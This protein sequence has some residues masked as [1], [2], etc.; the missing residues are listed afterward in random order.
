MA[1]E[2]RTV[3]HLPVDA[4]VPVF[5]IQ[6]AGFSLW[7][8]PREIPPGRDDVIAGLFDVS[9]ERL[10]AHLHSCEASDGSWAS[11]GCDVAGCRQPHDAGIFYK[12]M[13]RAD[14][15]GVTARLGYPHTATQWV[16]TRR[17]AL[18]AA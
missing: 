18:G 5:S 12:A 1:V 11:P 3:P 17:V 15:R 6:E 2:S 10:V 8:L 16:E 4:A 7:H 13:H 14:A 9:G